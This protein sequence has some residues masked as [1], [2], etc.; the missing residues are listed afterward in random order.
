MFHPCLEVSAV[1]VTVVVVVVVA[2]AFSIDFDH[3]GPCFMPALEYLPV[4]VASE[5]I[6]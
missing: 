2:V 5:E 6:F 1:A 4:L 3:E